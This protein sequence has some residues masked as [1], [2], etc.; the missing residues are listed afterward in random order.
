MSDLPPKRTEFYIGWASGMPAGTRL[1]VGSLVTIL[2][3]A[4]LG[5]AYGLARH[6]G[7]PG[8]GNYTD[9]ETLSGVLQAGAYPILRIPARQDVPA[10]AVMLAGD[11]KYGVAAQSADLNGRPVIAKGYGVKRGSLAMLLLD[12]QAGLKPADAPVQ[13]PS[14]LPP[15]SLGRWRLSGEICDGKCYAGAMR[16]GAGLAHKACANLC[17]SG[18]VPPVFVTALPI[19]GN[20]FLMMMAADGSLLPNSLF[21]KVGLPVDLDGEVMR[22]DDILLFR[23]D[24]TSVETRK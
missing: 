23:V 14:L 22:L 20:S 19:E 2:V 11:G 8:S 6:T 4:M 5:V 17:L 16:P 12:P 3:L 24:P 18:G 15:V 9:E 13:R 1:F 10:R 7:D 21:D